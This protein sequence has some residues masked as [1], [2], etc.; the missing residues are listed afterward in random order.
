[1]KR[2]FA[3]AAVICAAA[4]ALQA[5]DPKSRVIRRLESLNVENV[6]MAWADMAARWPDR[7]EKDPEWL[8][9]LD[10]RRKKI[11]SAIMGDWGPYY[12]EPAP[13]KGGELDKI[14]ELTDFGVKLEESVM[15][16]VESGIMTKDLALM[17]TLPDIKVLKMK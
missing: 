14:P 17:S 16:L 9:T 4:L 5:E 10:A 12:G 1:M 11:L 2:H 7:F 13:L 3:L 6:R 8:R 15:E